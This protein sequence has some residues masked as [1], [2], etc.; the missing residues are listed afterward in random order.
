LHNFIK[1]GKLKKI[2]I[3]HSIGKLTRKSNINNT[4]KKQ[5]NI[6]II[7]LILISLILTIIVIVT[8]IS[9]Y[10]CCSCSPDRYKLYPISFALLENHWAQYI[11]CS[12]PPEMECTV[13]FWVIPIDLIGL[14]VVLTGISLYKLKKR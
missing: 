12:C 14:I 11:D 9:P 3:I 1:I 4:M 6:L 5:R 7:S 2:D 10:K 8:K 13:S